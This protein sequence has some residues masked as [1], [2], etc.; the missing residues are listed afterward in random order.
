M[1]RDKAS[2]VAKAQRFAAKGQ[3]DK[4]IQEWEKVLQ[5]TPTDGNTHNI[6]GDLFLRK[7]E[8]EKA[9]DSFYRAA[10]YFKD[11][12]F[13]LKAMALYKKIIKF[14]PNGIEAHLRLAELN[15]DRGLIGNANENYLAAAEICVRNKEM[16][17][18]LQLYEKIMLLS[19]DNLLTHLRI[20]DLY[21]KI[22]LVSDSVRV[23]VRT[24]ERFLGRGEEE[25]A[26]KIFEKVI[27]LAPKEPDGYVGLSRLYHGRGDAA[28][29]A[30]VLDRAMEKIPENPKVLVARARIDHA[31]GRTDEARA[32]VEAVLAEEADQ[33]EA[34][35]L[36]AEIHLAAGR[37]EEAWRALETA[38][39]RLVQEE[40][41]GEANAALGIFA[42]VPARRVEVLRRQ[43]TLLRE[44]GQPEAAAERLKTLGGFLVDEGRREEAMRIYDEVRNLVPGDPEAEEKLRV[45]AG[46]SSAAAE[47]ETAEPDEGMIGMQSAAFESGGDTAFDIR[48]Y[49]EIGL[50]S[51]AEEAAGDSTPDDGLG[52]TQVFEI[53]EET[54]AGEESGSAAGTAEAPPD[55]AEA[56]GPE[57]TPEPEGGFPETPEDSAAE[58]TPESAGPSPDEIF[59]E[60]LAEADFYLEQG[61]QDEAIEIYQRLASDFPDR[62]EPKERLAKLLPEERSREVVLPGS[63]GTKIDMDAFFES[64]ADVEPDRESEKEE[65]GAEVAS[66]FEAFKKGV[67]EEVGEG[68]FETHYNLGIAYKEMGLLEDAIREFQLATRVEADS[69]QA[70]SMLA[71]CYLEQGAH[72]QAVFGYRKLLEGL[73]PDDER[74]ASVKYDLAVALEKS[75]DAEGALEIFRELHARDAAFRDVAQRVA[76]VD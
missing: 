4:A 13:A 10:G 68:D 21:S 43:A 46:V 33:V 2:I 61:L 29:A 1:A 20:A 49:Q 40:R 63:G 69:F 53:P 5:L 7:G 16:D 18:A 65:A 8:K 31:E 51:D 56:G 66:I 27:D 73:S 34:L 55:G 22:G 71:M 45:L 48:G 35:C 24:A 36:L 6:V 58:E 25:R 14:D 52:L 32:A 76:G 3:I 70:A 23:Y 72:E 74:Y 9:I 12:G 57:G 44:M 30:E 19:P 42:E 59:D 37:E 15:A 38:V 50:G 75:G 41:Y 17:R 60:D 67:E 47:E 54:A 28:R 26:E 11:Q 39:D 62:P 64:L